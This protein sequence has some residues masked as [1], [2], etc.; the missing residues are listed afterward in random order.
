[1]R[2][3]FDPDFDS[4]SWPGPLGGRDASAGEAWVGP[5]GLL[6]L[7]ETAVGVGGPVFSA[8]ERAAQL[9]PLFGSIDG[10]WSRSAEVDPFGSARR[11]LAWRDSLVMSGW[12]GGGAEPR[13]AQLSALMAQAPAGFPD[14]LLAVNALL[15]RR[16]PGLSSLTLLSPRE[17][18]APLDRKSV[19]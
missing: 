14:R 5:G 12:S 19:V 7:L 15:A 10:F 17:D 1:M 13:L 9:I 18:L 8:A 4:G 16:D 2:I 6:G 3:I 11:L